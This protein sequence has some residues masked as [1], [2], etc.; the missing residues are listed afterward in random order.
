MGVAIHNYNAAIRHYFSPNRC[1]HKSNNRSK[2]RKSILKIIVLLA[3]PYSSAL[4]AALLKTHT[5]ALLMNKVAY[6]RL[7]NKFKIGIKILV[8]ES[9]NTIRAIMIF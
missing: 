3:P 6:L 8:I 1:L 5:V 2:L 4:S 9:Y 7:L